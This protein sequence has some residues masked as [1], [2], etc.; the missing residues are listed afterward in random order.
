MFLGQLN[1]KVAIWLAES[2]WSLTVVGLDWLKVGDLGVQ[3]DGAHWATWHDT[4]PW[5]LKKLEHISNLP[6]IPTNKKLVQS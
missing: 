2:S 4:K 6:P 5:K 1:Q 3:G